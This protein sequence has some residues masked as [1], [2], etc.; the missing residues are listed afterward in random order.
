M[1]VVLQLPGIGLWV[2]AEKKS[3]SFTGQENWPDLIYH[4]TQDDEQQLDGLARHLTK[5]RIAKRDITEAIDWDKKFNLDDKR[6]PYAVLKELKW[7][8]ERWDHDEDIVQEG[9]TEIKSL[10]LDCNS[11]V[12]LSDF[13]VFDGKGAV[14]GVRHHQ[15]CLPTRSIIFINDKPDF[16]KSNKSIHDN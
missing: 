6:I 7:Q 1:E 5:G 12:P 14:G 4:I 2:T 9:K 3:C 8:Y 16:K 11:E 10:N 13:L 15:F